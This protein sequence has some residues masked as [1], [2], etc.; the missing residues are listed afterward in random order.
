MALEFFNN[1]TA[2]CSF[3]KVQPKI[4]VDE[5]EIKCRRHLFHY[6]AFHIRCFFNFSNQ[7]FFSEA[8]DSEIP[9]RNSAH[10]S[11]RLSLSIPLGIKAR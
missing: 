9:R 6:T 2:T 3:D 11:N 7:N 1:S 8:D 5:Y 10:K 4:E